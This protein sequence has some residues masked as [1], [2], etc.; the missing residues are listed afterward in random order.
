MQLARIEAGQ[1]SW[2]KEAVRVAELVQDVVERHQ[3]RAEQKGLRMVIEP[4]SEPVTAWV[5]ADALTRILENL[6]DNAIKYTL[7]G[8]ITVRWWP[9]DRQVVVEVADTG[10]GIPP[11]HLPRIFERFYRVDKGRSRSQGG[12]GLGL[13]IVKHLVQAMNGSIEVRSQPEVGTCF[14]VRLPSP[15]TSPTDAAAKQG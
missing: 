15:E 10:V 12:S 14:T 3:P 13:A 7:H 11:E 5:D 8:T 9:M 6:L 4:S 2:H 1:Q